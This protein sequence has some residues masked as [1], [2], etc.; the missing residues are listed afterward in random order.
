MNLNENME[1][2]DVVNILKQLQQ[3]K[4]P[5]AFETALMR[6]IN[7]E[8]IA[9]KSILQKVFIPSRLIPAASLAVAAIL[10]IFILNNQSIT[11]ENPF[12]TIPRE[13]HD[14]ALTLQKSNST[15]SIISKQ[16]DELKSGSNV[17]TENYTDHSVTSSSS[18]DN[19]IHINFASARIS[20]YPVNKAG[21][22]FRQV[23][24]SGEEKNEINQLKQKMDMRFQSGH[25]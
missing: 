2:R 6:K 25:K 9:E 14:V 1:Y 10:L 4:A 17:K 12:S 7:S 5:P 23:R 19:F 8:Q 18:N 16:K 15:E 20:D 21:L 22:N 13:R 24:L 3:V 11:Q